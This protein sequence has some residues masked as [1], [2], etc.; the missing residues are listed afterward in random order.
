MVGPD[1]TQSKGWM[2]SKDKNLPL[3]PPSNWMFLENKKWNEDSTLQFN[4]T[5]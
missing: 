3:I 5:Y 1:V 2:K 4:P